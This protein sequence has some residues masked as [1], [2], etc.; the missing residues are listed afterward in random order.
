MKTTDDVAQWMRCRFEAGAGY[1]DRIEA[2]EEMDGLF[3]EPFVR[4][5]NNGTVV[6]SRRILGAFRRLTPDAVLDRSERAWR[7][8]DESDVE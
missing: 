5:T 8:R 7:R 2:A 3:G 4:T 6:I 1:L